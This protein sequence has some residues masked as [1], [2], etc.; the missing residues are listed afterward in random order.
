[1]PSRMTRAGRVVVLA[2]II[3][4]CVGCDQATKLLAARHL[5]SGDGVAFLADT[6]R[7]HY[8]E[9]PG[10]FL[11]LGSAMAP[12]V[13]FIVF[14]VLVAGVLAVL[15]FHVVLNQKLTPVEILATALVIGG[16]L[17]NLV[18]RLWLGV[19]R[20]FANI[21]VG[22]LRTGIFNVADMA[23]TAGVLMLAVHVVSCILRRGQE[24]E[25]V[26]K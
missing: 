1:M 7:L 15:C 8:A 13:R 12:S 6:V 17:G 3:A 14:V 19:V 18:D 20:D 25:G 10:G 16:G 5:S 11:S 4:S 22:D 2:V 23:I 24:P 9:N 21:G 26:V